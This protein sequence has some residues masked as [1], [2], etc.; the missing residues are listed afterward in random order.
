MAGPGGGRWADRGRGGRRPRQPAR[1]RAGRPAG[2]RLPRGHRAHRGAPPVPPGRSAGGDRLLR[3]DQRHR[4]QQQHAAGARGRARPRAVDT[5]PALPRPPA[6]ARPRLVRRRHGA[7]G[8]ADR[9]RLPNHARGRAVRP[10]P[11][12]PAPRRRQ[13]GAVRQEHVELVTEQ[14]ER[15]EQDRGGCSPRPSTPSGTGSPGNCTTSSCTR[16]ASSPCRARPSNAGSARPDRA[17][18]TTSARSD[19]LAAVERTAREA[20]TEMRQLFGVLRAGDGPPQLAPQPGL[21]QLD[22]LLEDARRGRP[23]GSTPRSGCRDRELTAGV[24]LTAYRSSRNRSPT[25]SSTRREHR[26]ATSRSADPGA[27]ARGLD[28]GPHAPPRRPGRPRP[29]RHAGAGR[30]LRRRARGRGAGRGAASGWPPG[31]LGR[32]GAWASA[33]CSPTTRRWCGPASAR[34]LEAEA[35]ITVVGEAADGE[36]AVSRPGRGPTSS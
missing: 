17:D 10:V 20:M 23:A 22:R 19:D 9:R 2:R 29:R 24:E 35:G 4:R 11:L 27:G 14:A 3:R 18:T 26:R 36:E 13:R 34:S 32:G 21:G 16:S 6:G 12:R 15:A 7:R 28:D 33:S 1:D 8:A 25:C 31:C 30:G 5:G